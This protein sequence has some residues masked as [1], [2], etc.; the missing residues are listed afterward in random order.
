MRE[1]TQFKPNKKRINVESHGSGRNDDSSVAVYESVKGR[2]VS[3]SQ[4]LIN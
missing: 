1:K 3:G 4:D 2:H